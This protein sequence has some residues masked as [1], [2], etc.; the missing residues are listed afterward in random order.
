MGTT[1][2]TKASPDRPASK[3]HTTML[4]SRE[5]NDSRYEAGKATFPASPPPH[6]LPADLA[7]KRVEVA[8]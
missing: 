7:L 1:E 4:H 8:A 6:L 3:K 5:W 2:T